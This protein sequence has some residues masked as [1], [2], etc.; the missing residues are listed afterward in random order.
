MD[1]QDRISVDPSICH[2]QP[3]IAGTRIPVT[4]I[5]DNLA[6]GTDINEL[7]ADYPSLGE[8]DV[9]AAMAYA[10]ALARESRIDL[11]AA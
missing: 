1:W 4:V 3:C 10:A 9:R 11:G 5:L 2:G 7:L 8:A 6:E